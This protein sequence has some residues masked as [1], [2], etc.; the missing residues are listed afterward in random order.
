[1]LFLLK[2]NFCVYVFLLTSSS[3]I[4]V[5]SAFNLS[6]TITFPFLNLISNLSVSNFFFD[7][8]DGFL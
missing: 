6:P 3:L 1:M 8:A 7:S 4:S 2:F 5:M